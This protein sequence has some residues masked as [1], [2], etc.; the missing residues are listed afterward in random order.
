MKWFLNQTSDR[1]SQIKMKSI[2]SSL[3]NKYTCFHLVACLLAVVDLLE[4]DGVRSEE[5]SQFGQ[6]DAISQPLLQL[7]GGG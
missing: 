5:V 4:G 3:M 6:I 2:L 7:G 1:H